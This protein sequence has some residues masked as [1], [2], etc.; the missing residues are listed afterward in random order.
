MKNLVGKLLER[1]IP[2][3]LVVYLGVAWGIMQFTQLI[4]DV[5]LFSP[6]WTKI[7]I[8][9]TFM[10][11]P[12]YLL[13]VYRHGRPGTDAWGLPEKI[14]IPANLLL[15]FAVLF[16]TFRTEDLGPA[17]TSVTVATK[18]APSWSVKS[19]SRSFASAPCS[20]TSTPMRSRTRI[21]G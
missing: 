13:V 5:F 8:F 3:F 18:P 20:S 2:Q 7:A 17:T 4:V 6:H 1:R 16:F 19:Q 14:G 9:A 11:W 10:L 21:S 15:A 12:S